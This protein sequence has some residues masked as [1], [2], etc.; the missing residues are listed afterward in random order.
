MS[1]PQILIDRKSLLDHANNL[2][3]PHGVTHGQVGSQPTANPVFT[4]V[5]KAGM[6]VSAGKTTSDPTNLNMDQWTKFATWVC[7]SRYSNSHTIIEAVAGNTG[8]SG[9]GSHAIFKLRVQQQNAMGSSPSVD[10]TFLSTNNSLTKDDVKAVLVENSVGRTQVDFYFKTRAGWTPIIFTPT[11]AFGLDGFTFYS[12]QPFIASLPAGTVWNGVDYTTYNTSGNGERIE[13]GYL[14]GT[15]A[16][17]A[18]SATPS[19]TFAKAF[20]VPPRVITQLQGGDAG[21]RWMVQV[22][23]TTTGFNTVMYRDDLAT[24]GSSDMRGFAWV[25]IGY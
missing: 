12:S 6:M 14:E 23:P 15:I 4:G 7:L 24:L 10:I 1:K 13:Y 20:T 5:G 2:Q 9:S 18:T 22:M 8:A 16:A 17:S 25:A 11:I 19:A 3:N 21:K